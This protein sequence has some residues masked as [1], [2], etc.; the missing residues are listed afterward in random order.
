[1]ARH[2]HSAANHH[3]SEVGHAPAHRGLAFGYRQ[4]NDYVRAIPHLKRATELDPGNLDY[5]GM[6]GAVYRAEGLLARATAVL[7]KA[8]SLDPSFT[9]PEIDGEVSVGA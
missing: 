8:Q 1:M 5:L 3:R 7:K 9:L 4:R 6:L 2:H